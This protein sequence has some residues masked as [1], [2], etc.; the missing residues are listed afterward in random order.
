MSL[1]LT[2]GSLNGYLS[3]AFSEKELLVSLGTYPDFLI[4]IWNWRNGEK[5]VTQ[6]SVLREENQMLKCNFGSVFSIEGEQRNVSLAIKWDGIRGHTTPC[7][8]WHKNGIV[9]AGPDGTIKLYT[10]VARRRA[11]ISKGP[12]PTGPA[13]KL[14]WTAHPKYPFAALCGAEH[15]GI[16]ELYGFTVR[17]ELY[18]LSEN[19]LNQVK[20]FGAGIKDFY[21]IYPQMDYIVTLNNAGNLMVWYKGTGQMVAGMHLGQNC[22]NMHASPAAPLLAVGRSD[23]YIILV[24]VE[25]PTEP[26]IVGELPLCLDDIGLLAFTSS[27]KHLLAGTKTTGHIF[28]LKVESDDGMPTLRPRLKVALASGHQIR[29]TTVRLARDVVVT[30][31]AD[32]L[33]V[34]RCAATLRPLAAITGHHRADGGVARARTDPGATMLLSL[35]YDGAFVATDMR[36]PGCALS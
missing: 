30:W 20:N 19:N 18:S 3:I 1:S 5:L 21:F 17:G 8:A 25:K 12:A 32:G 33:V 31:G 16:H 10:V 29:S 7:M 14:V 26:T 36:A 2:G 34:L 35:G 4:T 27:G 15:H 9:L 24:S 11:S 13:W 22:H 23:G 6:E 28:V